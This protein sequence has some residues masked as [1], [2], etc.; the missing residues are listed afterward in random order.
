[1]SEGTSGFSAAEERMLAHLLDVVIP[2]SPDGR[3]PAAGALG[4]TAHIAR[5]VA[6]TP[7]L[8]PVVDHG[9]STLAELARRR[10]PDGWEALSADERSAVLEEF[11][12]ADQ[13]FL[14]AFLFLAY[15]GYY[16]DPRVLEALGLEA[17]P[18]HPEGYAMEPDDLSLLEPVRRRGAIYRD[19]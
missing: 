3:L 18:P 2:A 12:A 11:T 1:M 19:C 17:R 16:A 10:H 4:L 13:F 7:M 15:S 14:P 9:L 8:R 5:A 6:R